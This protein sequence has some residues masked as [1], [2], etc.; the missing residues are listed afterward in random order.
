MNDVSIV[1]YCKYVCSKLLYEGMVR[2]LKFLS[3]QMKRVD[4]EDYVQF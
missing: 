2:K 4:I 1:W 3:H